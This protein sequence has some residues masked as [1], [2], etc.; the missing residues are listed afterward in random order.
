MSPWPLRVK[1]DAK[2]TP[3]DPM[4]MTSI[5]APA[6]ITTF[7]AAS[8]ARVW[9]P[10]A[11]ESQSKTPSWESSPP[12]VPMVTRSTAAASPVMVAVEP[13]TE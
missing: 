3:G 12:A 8:S 4:V 7:V 5:P 1:L 6:L 9:S 11:T 10:A 2:A 13:T